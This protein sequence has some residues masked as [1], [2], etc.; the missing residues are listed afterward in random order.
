MGRTVAGGQ[1]PLVR[2]EGALSENGRGSGQEAA[3]RNCCEQC[4]FGFHNFDPDIFFTI[5]IDTVLKSQADLLPAPN[6]HKVRAKVNLNI[7][8]S[9]SFFPCFPR[10]SNFY[11][12]SPNSHLPSSGRERERAGENRKAGPLLRRALAIDEKS[13]GPEHLSTQTIRANLK[14]LYE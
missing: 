4:Y 2:K 12:Q 10:P 8:I 7:K 3:K 9:I 1:L 6:K 11:L 5:R 14:L 13:F